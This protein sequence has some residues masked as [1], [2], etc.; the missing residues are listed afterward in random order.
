MSMGWCQSSLHCRW[1]PDV[2]AVVSPLLRST[3]CCWW[4]TAHR[5]QASAAAAGTLLDAAKPPH[6]AVAEPPPNRCHGTATHSCRRTPVHSASSL[7]W[8]GTNSE[9]ETSG[10]LGNVWETGPGKLALGNWP[11]SLSIPAVPPNVMSPLKR[12]M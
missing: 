8:V 10:K 6:T 11:W 7:M 1:L 9:R 12:E 2:V 4:S 3:A 5:Y